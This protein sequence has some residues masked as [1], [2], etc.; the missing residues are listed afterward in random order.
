MR[1]KVLSLLVVMAMVFTTLVPTSF[2][3]IASSGDDVVINTTITDGM[4]VKGSKLAVEVIAIKN[5]SKIKAELTLNGEN[6]IPEWSDIQKDTFVLNFTETGPYQVKISA[7]GKTD[8]YTINYQKAEKGDF[9]GNAVFCLELLTIGEGYIAQPMQIP[10]Y[11]GD[12]AAKALDRV[13]TELGYSYENTGS[14]ESAFYLAQ[15]G[16]GGFLRNG[17]QEAG[18][19]LKAPVDPTDN[20]PGRLKEKM[21]EAGAVITPK[22]YEIDEDGYAKTLGEFDYTPMSGW[23]V[24]LNNSMTNV[25]FSDIYLADGDVLRVQF[26]IYGYG[27]DLGYGW[28]TSWYTLA[29]KTQLLRTLGEINSSSIKSEW[30]ADEAFKTEYDKA[31]AAGE[32][33]F[34]EQE[35]VSE[36]VTSLGTEYSR[37]KVSSL[38]DAFENL[39]NNVTWNDAKLIA[40]YRRLFN[41]LPSMDKTKVKNSDILKEAEKTLAKIVSDEIEAIPEHQN[42]IEEYLLTVRKHYGELTDESKEY[43][44]N[45]VKVEKAEAKVFDDKVEA[46][47]NS[48][49]KEDAVK[50]LRES[51][52]KLASETKKYVS[53]YV[54]LQKA[55]AEVV[56]VKIND[57][58]NASDKEAACKSARSALEGLPKGSEQFVTEIETL[59]RAE[60][61]VFDRKVESIGEVDYSDKKLVDDLTYE[62]EYRLD[63]GVKKF[64]TKSKELYEAD[65]IISALDKDVIAVRKLLNKLPRNASSVN[66]SH[67][68]QVEHA[69]AEYDKLPKASQEGINF[70]QY[71]RLVNAEKKLAEID[72]IKLNEKISELGKVTINDY[73]YVIELDSEYES[74][75]QEGKNK[76]TEVD[77]LKAAVKEVK[78]LQKEIDDVISKIDEIGDVT[79]EDEALIVEIADKLENLPEESIAKITNREEFLNSVRLFKK[80]KAEDAIAAEEAKAFDEKVAAI[81]KVSLESRSLIEAAEKAYDE[82]SDA[83][84]KKATKYAELKSARE[85]YD[86]LV[87]ADKK[88]AEEA[89]AFDEK[90]AAI[91]K[92]SLESRS[93]IEEAEKMYDEL[94]DAAKKKATK[95]AELKAAR[96]EY[97][98]LVAADKKAVE[99]AKAVDEKIIAIGKVSL[100]SKSLID[101]A[102]K[103]YN[104]LSDAAKSKVTEKDTLDKARIEYER[105]AKEQADREEAE[106]ADRKAAEE[107][108]DVDE[109]IN[110]IGIVTLES[111]ERII[112]ARNAYNE[113]SDAAAIKVTGL[114]VLKDAEEKLNELKKADEADK[115][116]ENA[117]K[118]VDEKITA[119][120]KVSL[121]SKNVIEEAEKAYDELSEA[122]KNKVTKYEELKAARTEFD[123]LV[124]SESDKDKKPV[125]PEIPVK[126]VINAVNE[127]A[128]ITIETIKSA[129][130]T[131]LTVGFNENMSIEYSK[132]AISE[133]LKQL[134]D[135]ATSIEVRLLEVNKTDAMNQAQKDAVKNASGTKVFSITLLVMNSDGTVHEIHDFNGGN[136]TITVDYILKD[137]DNTV[138][139]YRVEADGTL[140]LMNSS[141]KDG[142]LT[143]VTD[144]HSFYT[145]VEKNGTTQKADTEKNTTPKTGDTEAISLWIVLLIAAVTAVPFMRRRIKK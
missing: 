137:K 36:L 1:K 84:K 139:V 140:K 33:L 26:T 23:M 138:E 110:S 97:D 121:D 15:I 12:N 116:A 6:V 88:A 22:E 55:E 10:V 145:V 42:D 46:V 51:Y 77:K 49:N 92:V 106:A 70:S 91:G 43:V 31:I 61:A 101:G 60:A 100:E 94:S 17:C 39:N 56:N 122:A 124:K 3:D 107:A 86:N 134:P 27:A 44:T 34:A 83:A 120:G 32:D 95:Y 73:E 66:E 102:E 63:E 81:G 35:Y 25:G 21:D 29:D 90:V 104:E 79:L 119:I 8:E 68:E 113:L 53:R 115:Q 105:L 109:I 80:L 50:E 72:G 64:I 117:A 69:R 126:P 132:E 89:K 58:A 37:V 40:E 67:R 78:A 142:K 131:G 125:N 52:E 144:G 11:E 75:L 71:D 28:G 143:W 135:N 4:T 30:M 20:I 7:G 14:I 74:L 45:F 18:T 59:Q 114:Q 57:I 118:I 38:M 48:D 85:E 111:E 65:E 13:L 130:D 82:L 47:K 93:L 99:D 123:K 54:D 112:E 108:R 24:T 127:V 16:D 133:I 103:A 76:V 9:I 129:A 41:T 136:A 98:N 87:A 141:F 96:E 19:R 62:Y 128:K 2:A 5:D